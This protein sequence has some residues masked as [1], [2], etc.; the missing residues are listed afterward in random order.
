MTKVEFVYTTYIKSTQQKVWD[1][2][3]TPEFTR[4]YWGCELTSDWKKGSSWHSVR[5]ADGQT[6]MIGK[7]LESSPID[8]LSFS[9]HLPDSNQESDQSRVTYKLETIA[10]TVKLMV[11][12]DKLE[13]GS[14]MAT[15]ISQGWPLVLSSLK[16]FLETGTALDVWSLKPCIAAST[17]TKQEKVGAK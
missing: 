3:T 7:V 13:S 16:S 1:A 15:N 14:T 11:I 12:H 17:Q 8:E 6:N 2:L 5:N 9:W 4:Q 10:D